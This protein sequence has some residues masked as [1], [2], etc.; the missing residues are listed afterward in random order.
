MCVTEVPEGEGREN[1][2]EEISRDNHREFPK[3]IK[4]NKS[5]IHE[6]QRIPNWINTKKHTHT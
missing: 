1:G 6:A 5:P 3:L 2:A 4:D